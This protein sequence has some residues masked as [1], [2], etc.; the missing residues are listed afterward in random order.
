MDP[1]KGIIYGLSQS[2]KAGNSLC[3]ALQMENWLTLIIGLQAVKVSDCARALNALNAC[4]A[5]PLHDGVYLLPDSDQCRETL[6]AI[7]RNILSVNGTACLLPRHDG[8]GERF[9]ELFD[10]RADYAKLLSELEECRAQ[11]TPE[12]AIVTATKFHKLV[13]A[14]TQL[15]G[16]DFFPGEARERVSAALH[17]AEAVIS[18]ALIVAKSNHSGQ[19]ISTQPLSE[20]PD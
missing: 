14:F 6:A 17:E 7:E 15:A 11:L 2:N 5:I 8:Q 19:P 12:T 13:K 18:L 16:I 10:R 3:G 4:G 9:I 20:Q 1:Q